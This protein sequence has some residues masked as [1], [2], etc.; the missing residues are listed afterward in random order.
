MWMFVVFVQMLSF[1]SDVLDDNTLSNIHIQKPNHSI[2]MND[3]LMNEK[4]QT[5]ASVQ[6]NV[7]LLIHF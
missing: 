4:L 6:T 7:K 1:Q 2:S 3:M 5:C